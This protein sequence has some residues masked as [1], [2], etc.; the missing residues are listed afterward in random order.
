MYKDDRAWGD[1]F[2]DQAFRILT[3]FIPQCVEL[4]LA[5]QYKDNKEATDFEIALKGGTIAV[6]LRRPSYNFRD[7]TIRSRRA[8]GART[9]LAKLQAGYA[10]RYFYGWTDERH[11]IR[12][13]ILVDL[14]KVR[15]AGLLHRDWQ[16]KPNKDGTTFFIAIPSQALD[17]AG[18]LIAKQL[19]IQKPVR[20]VPKKPPLFQGLPASSIPMW[21]CADKTIPDWG[22]A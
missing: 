13:W 4:T 2:T 7:L 3:P 5:P 19:K 15:Q 12:E 17:Q 10:F 18:C 11:N 9:E 6:R 21:E 16:E 22:S 14:D 8:N 20:Q 1:A